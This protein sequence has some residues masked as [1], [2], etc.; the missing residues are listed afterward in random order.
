MDPR[1]C[2]AVSEMLSIMGFANPYDLSEDEKTPLDIHP[3]A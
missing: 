1:E 2:L 3:A